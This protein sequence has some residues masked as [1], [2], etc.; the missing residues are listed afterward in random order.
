MCWIA[1]AR[2][3]QIREEAWFASELYQHKHVGLM[4]TDNE[5]TSSHHIVSG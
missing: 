4:K 1:Y 5:F 3:S 2:H